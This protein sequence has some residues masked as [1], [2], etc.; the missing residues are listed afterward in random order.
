MTLSVR[1]IHHISNIFFPSIYN[2][3]TNYEV[4]SHIYTIYIHDI[5]WYLPYIHSHCITL[6]IYTKY[7]TRSFAQLPKI[8][9]GEVSTKSSVKSE[10]IAKSKPFLVLL[11]NICHF[12]PFLKKISSKLRQKNF[13]NDF[14]HPI[15]DRN[16]LKTIISTK[17]TETKTIQTLLGRYPYC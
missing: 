5:N 12:E 15:S 16:M 9:S 3:S 7:H 2:V 11:S 13:S 17:E 4:S 6:H 14:F 10:K 8:F 1:Y